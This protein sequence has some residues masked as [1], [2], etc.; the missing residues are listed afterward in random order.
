MR[1][2]RAEKDW[3]TTVRRD[4]FLGCWM[5]LFF[6]D[7]EVNCFFGIPQLPV[8]KWEI[9]SILRCSECAR[10]P[11]LETFELEFARKH[12]NPKDWRV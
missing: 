2:K 6:G 3:F 7:S 9:F 8:P 12:K 11:A 4:Y 10:P 1:I 5:N